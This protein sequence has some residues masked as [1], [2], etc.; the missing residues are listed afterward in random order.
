MAAVLWKPFHYIMYKDEINLITI[1]E[2]YARGDWATAPNAYWP[3]LLS[4]IEAFAFG[5]G[6]PAAAVKLVS[7][8]IG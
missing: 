4:W 1:A 6:L 2:R 5:M 3:P 8:L 7:V